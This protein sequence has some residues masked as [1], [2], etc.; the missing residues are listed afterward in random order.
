MKTSRM[1]HGRAHSS[2]GEKLFRAA[3]LLLL[4]LVAGAGLLISSGSLA[5][6]DRHPLKRLTSTPASASNDAVSDSNKKDIAGSS[7]KDEQKASQRGDISPETLQQIAALEAEKTS[8]TASEQKIDSQLL[9]A[10][11]ESRGQQMATGVQLDRANVK[12]DD[13]GR[14]EVDISTAVNDDLLS[15]IEGLGGE[16]IYPSWEYKTV[17]VRVNL[18]A[19]ETI[20]RFSEVRFIQPAVQY[21]L[22]RQ[23][24]ASALTLVAPDFLAGSGFLSR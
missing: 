21:M 8:R 13:A 19:V 18:S 6:S 20:A 9:Q 10:I 14:V 12:A 16:I 1:R 5:K 24:N 3:L 23:R 17:R 22:D 4:A 2:A 7:K 15:K 11:R